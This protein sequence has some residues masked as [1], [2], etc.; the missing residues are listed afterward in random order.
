M[1]VICQDAPDAGCFGARYKFRRGVAK[2]ADQQMS[3][4]RTWRSPVS[5]VAADSAAE[6]FGMRGVLLS[7]SRPRLEE[8]AA[9]SGH[10][11]T[12]MPAPPVSQ[13]PSAG[14][15]GRPGSP[16]WER[17][18]SARR[19][20]WKPEMAPRTE[21]LPEDWLPITTICGTATSSS[22]S[23]SLRVSRLSNRALASGG[24]NWLGGCC[25]G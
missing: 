10:R 25:P 21:L 14:R 2:D 19:R 5:Y 9:G 3:N 11:L 22:T 4:V 17:R 18:S 12:P 15:L 6:D 8:S 20:N 16:G 7:G 23:R 1:L 13:Y 24:H